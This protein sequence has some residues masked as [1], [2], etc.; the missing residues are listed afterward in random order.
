MSVEKKRETEIK[1]ENKQDLIVITSL[2]ENEIV[3]YSKVDVCGK[4]SEGKTSPK[5]CY[6]QYRLR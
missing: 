5:V 6:V 2:Y 1:N 3:T 4:M